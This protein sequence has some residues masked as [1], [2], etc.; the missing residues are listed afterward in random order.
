MSCQFADGKPFK[1]RIRLFNDGITFRY[2]VDGLDR[3][4]I[5]DEQTAYR[6]QEGTRRWIQRWTEAYEEFYEKI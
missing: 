3:E 1:I 4:K 6:I 2:E 5:T